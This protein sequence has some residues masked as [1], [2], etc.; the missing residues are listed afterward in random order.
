MGDAEIISATVLMQ[1]V[2]PGAPVFHSLMQAWADPSSGNYVSY[3]LDARGRYAPVEMA[4][5]WG[6]PA[7]GACYGTDSAEPGT[8]Q[9]A[10]EP[11]LD[12]FMVALTG[13]EIV[14]GMGLSNTY[15]HLYPEQLLMD[16]DLYQRARYSL[17]A[18]DI[19]PETLALEAIHAVGPGGHFLANRH[20]RTHMRNAMVRGITHQVGSDGKYRDPREFAIERTQWILAN[21]HPDPLEPAKHAELAQILAAADKELG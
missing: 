20:T 12:P 18:P 21:H 5:N 17:T 3:P 11:A 15:T 4:H 19:S 1:M 8:W 13:A 2:A 7:L 14:T 10:A 6:M 9:A 16:V